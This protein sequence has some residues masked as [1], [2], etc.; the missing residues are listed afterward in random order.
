MTRINCG[1]KPYELCDKHLL[2]ESREIKRIPNVVSKGKYNINKIP[3]E[4]KLGEGHVSFFYDK[5]L[6]LKN[7]YE[8]IYLECKDRG[9]NV[10][11]FGNAWDKIPN[12][13]MNDYKPSEKDRQIVLERINERLKTMK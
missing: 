7:R 9:F 1:I 12:K 5:L 6:Y 10:T 11:Y 2:A 4:F 3:K 13:L 8:E